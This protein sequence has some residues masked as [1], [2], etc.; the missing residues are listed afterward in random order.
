MEMKIPHNFITVKNHEDKKILLDQYKIVTESLNKINEI[1][2]TANTFWTGLN[3]ALIGGIAYLRDAEGF[4]GNQRL[5]FILT[6]IFLGIVFSFSWLSYLVTI[7]KSVD[8]RNDILI[9]IEKYLP[10][11]VFTM[12][13]YKMGRKEGREGSL[14]FKE[15][16]VPTLSLMCYL[17][18]FILFYYD[19]K[20]ILPD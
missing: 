8:M 5:S 3:V 2:E 17:L 1:R 11:K 15:M 4:A 9:A 18:F 10:A 6:M 12:C 16:L 20:I 19:P 14:S 13:I 7:K